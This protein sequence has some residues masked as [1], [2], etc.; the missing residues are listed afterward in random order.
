MDDTSTNVL[1]LSIELGRRRWQASRPVATPES[2]VVARPFYPRRP[3]AAMPT[4][5]S[6]FADLRFARPTLPP[7]DRSW[8]PGGSAGRGIRALLS[9]YSPVGVAGAIRVHRA[10]F[11]TSSLH[12]GGGTTGRPAA[13]EG[14]AAC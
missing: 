1:Y 5:P 6:A 14:G 9:V 13:G 7:G 8:L 12:A 3:D 11:S 2:T 4:T 10:E